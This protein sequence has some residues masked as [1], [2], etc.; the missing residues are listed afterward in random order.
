MF[1]TYNNQP[2]EEEESDKDLEKRAF[3]RRY[4]RK[5]KSLYRRKDS[6]GAH[7]RWG[8]YILVALLEKEANKDQLNVD[9]ST[10]TVSEFSDYIMDKVPNDAENSIAINEWGDPRFKNEEE[11]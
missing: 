3:K 7:S 2:N 10:K 11:N 4:K 8:L 6:Y 5:R 9:G 1:K